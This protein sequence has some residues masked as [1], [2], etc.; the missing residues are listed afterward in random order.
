MKK[1][2]L[3]L[4][5]LTLSL[6]SCAKPSPYRDIHFFAMDT[7]AEVRVY[8]SDTSANEALIV[9]KSVAEDLENKISTT[10]EESDTYAFN[11]GAAQEYSE[12][13]TEL[14][15]LSLELSK[16]TDGA[17]DMT[18]GALIELWTSCEAEGR[19]PTDDELSVA[20]SNAGYTGVQISDDTVTKQNP[21]LLLDFGAIG[22]GYA[23]D[24]MAESLRE[25][26][27]SC[28]MISFVSSVTVFGDKD[29]KIG[30][31]K[32]DTSGELFG[33]VSLRDRSLSVS[34]DYERFYEIGGVRYPHILDPKNGMPIANGIHSVVVLA[35]SGAMADALS[36]AVFVM[37]IEKAATLYR[38][39]ELSFEFL[40]MTD[41]GAVASD[42]FLAYFEPS[43]KGE[44]PLSLSQY[45]SER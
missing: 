15:R 31:R 14:L 27:V 12:D 7:F 5:L 44:Q 6:G 41:D 28:G 21:G 25:S 26:G 23:A 32:P 10:K 3:L 8:T 29:F 33:Y 22:K 1:M 19:L 13:F 4:I 20:L 18:S 37:G 42:G 24:R 17:F 45:I 43:V 11:H 16:F 9:G 2:A 39:A 35:D 40:C 34:G 36:T 38:N 30:I